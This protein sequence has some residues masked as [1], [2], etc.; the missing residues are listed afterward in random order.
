MS[1][2]QSHQPFDEESSSNVETVSEK[3][4]GHQNE[5][6]SRSSGSN[7]QSTG[8]VHDHEAASS[9]VPQP[10]VGQ[11]SSLG[12]DPQGRGKS[13]SRSGHKKAS[14]EKA[15]DERHEE[16]QAGDTRREAASASLRRSPRKKRTGEP[17]WWGAM[18]PDDEEMRPSVAGQN[19]DDPTRPT[20]KPTNASRSET[21]G[22]SNQTRADV[23]TNSKK[24]NGKQYDSDESVVF[25]SEVEGDSEMEYDGASYE[26]DEQSESE[27]DEDK[28]TLAKKAKGKGSRKKVS[29]R[30]IDEEDGSEESED[31]HEK[32]GRSLAKKTKRKRSKKRVSKRKNHHEAASQESEDEHEKAGKKTKGESSRKTQASKKQINKKADRN[33]TNLPSSKKTGEKR[34]RSR[35]K[36]D[37]TTVK[38]LYV[39][40][41]SKGK[42]N[43]NEVE[44]LQEKIRKQSKGLPSRIAAAKNRTPPICLQKKKNTNIRKST[45]H[46][47]DEAGKG[48]QKKVPRT[49]G[50]KKLHRYRP[51]TV[52]LR[53]IR[54]YQKCTDTLIRKMP[55]MR[56]VREIAQEFKTDLRFQGSALAA[57]QQAAELYMSLYFEKS[58]LAAIHARRVTIFPKDMHLVTSIAHN[59][60]PSLAAKMTPNGILAS[61]NTSRYWVKG[62]FG[63]KF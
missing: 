45:A 53:E 13:P 62:G 22:G 43:S 38:E 25:E 1:E 6:H 12:T 9:C 28:R 52:A 55:F 44:N 40:G 36:S 59:F 46:G 2:S 47:S 63:T 4:D 16:K 21:R 39:E 5:S 24:S 30:K 19:E 42:K 27:N 57:L 20:D 54:K 60:Q 23:K 48:K 37:K 35:M 11:A 49:G 31:E 34:G 18:R 56:I 10:Q 14:E 3:N 17:D 61:D 50:V 29:K 8:A 26:T 41:S 15:Q 32:D 33:E 51:G 7:Q 58:N